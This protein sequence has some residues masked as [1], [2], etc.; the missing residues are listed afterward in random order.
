[1][2]KQINIFTTVLLSLFLLNACKNTE[3]KKSS[4]TAITNKSSPNCLYTSSDGE[5]KVISDCKLQGKLILTSPTDNLSYVLYRKDD[6][7]YQHPVLC[8]LPAQAAEALTQIRKGNIAVPIPKGTITA[9][10]EKQDNSN[11]ILLNKD[12]EMSPSLYVL[13]SNFALCMS[14]GSNAI[15]E[16]DFAKLFAKILDNA[17]ISAKKETPPP[18]AK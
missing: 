16:I 6:P 3:E 17:V 2:R 18:K 9:G 12:D 7:N 4:I 10:A 1:M 13:S 5:T 15:N 11:I 8:T 14:Y